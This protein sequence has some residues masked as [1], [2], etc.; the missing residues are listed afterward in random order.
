MADRYAQAVIDDVARSETQGIVA[1]SYATAILA[2]SMGWE[3][4]DWPAVNRAILA[5]WKHSGL[6][7]IKRDAWKLAREPGP[8][9]PGEAAGG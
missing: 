1:I 4:I 5:R 7:R 2:D 3:S 6:D 8:D 9:E